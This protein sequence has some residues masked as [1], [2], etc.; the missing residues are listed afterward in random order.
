MPGRSGGRP[1]RFIAAPML[2]AAASV[3][4]GDERTCT[5]TAGNWAGAAGRG[6]GTQDAAM[7]ASWGVDDLK[8]GRAQ[9]I[10]AHCAPRT[11]ACT[12]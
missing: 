3:E 10:L 7:L 5:Q 1:L 2:T 9:R 8:R 12:G 6:R 11:P 4:P